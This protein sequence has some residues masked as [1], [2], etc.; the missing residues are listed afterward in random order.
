M[1]LIIL[2]NHNIILILTIIMELQGQAAARAR[3]EEPGRRQGRGAEER[4]RQED[5]YHITL[6]YRIV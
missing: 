2:L 1:L 4:V 3:A 5:S 6:S